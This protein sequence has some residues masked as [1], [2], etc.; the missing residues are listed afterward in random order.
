MPKKSGR[1]S[2]KR[3]DAALVERGLF[4]TR[5]RARAA[6]M[7]GEVLVDGEPVSKPGARVAADAELRVREKP[8]YVSRGGDKLARALAVFGIDPAGKRALDVGASTGGFTH[9]LLEGGAASVHAV[10]VGYGQLAPSLRGDPRVT[11]AERTNI[12]NVAP[13][14]VPH[15]FDLAVIDVSFISL[16]LVLPVVRELLAPG[17]RIV[18]LVKPQFEAGKGKVGKGGVVRDPGLHGE[19]LEGVVSFCGGAGLAAL[20]AAASPLRG[21]KGNIEFFLFIAKSGETARAPVSPE[22][23]DRVVEEAHRSFD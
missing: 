6:V 9:C 18:A 12:R 15:A 11:V 4:E 20:E 21:P 13:D 10:D 17:A 23:I 1:V 7:A 8:G 19:V 5:E 2:K 16:R 14:G 3:L 22:T